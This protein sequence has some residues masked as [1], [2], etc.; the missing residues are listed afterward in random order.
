MFFYFQGKEVIDE[1]SYAS[2]ILKEANIPNPENK[3]IDI[4]APTDAG[5]YHPD[6][7]KHQSHFLPVL[8]E[9]KSY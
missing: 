6:T 1:G 3:V 7:E 9:L 8:T 2:N 5:R 4:D